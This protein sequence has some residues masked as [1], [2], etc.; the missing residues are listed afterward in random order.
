MLRKRPL[1]SELAKPNELIRDR[2]TEL[3]SERFD[4]EP[5]E[6][7]KIAA[8]PFDREPERASASDKDR[9]REVCSPKLEAEPIEALRCT[10]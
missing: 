9:N 5:N 7:L 4:A 2:K 10:V 6:A 1:V 8:R 3:R